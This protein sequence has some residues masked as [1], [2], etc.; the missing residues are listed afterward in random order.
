VVVLALAAACADG[1]TG[2]ESPGAIEASVDQSLPERSIAVEGELEVGSSLQA[3]VSPDLDG[4]VASWGWHRCLEVPSCLTVDGADG[5]GYELSEADAWQVLRV[6]A[7]AER[8]DGTSGAVETRIG[9]VVNP[10]PRPFTLTRRI[11]LRTGLSAIVAPGRAMVTVD[12]E[13]AVTVFAAVKTP[14]SSGAEVTGETESAAATHHELEVTGDGGQLVVAA[15]GEC[16]EA[17]VTID[18]AR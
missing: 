4:R 17:T 12:A 11:E 1:D 2:I 3:V 18:A 9:P 14:A 5:P 8:A 6:I 10:D 15:D 16:D 7:T 13:C